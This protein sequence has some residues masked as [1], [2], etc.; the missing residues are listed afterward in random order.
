MRAQSQGAQGAPAQ[1]RGAGTT[2]AAPV[3]PDPRTMLLWEGTPPGAQGTADADIPTLT[4]Y[5]AYGRMAQTAVIVA[6]GGGYGNLAMNHEGRQVANWLNSQGIAAFV[7]KYRLGPRYHHP[8]PLT[9]ALQAIKTVRGRAKEL[10]LDPKR[11]GIWGFSAGGH[12]ASTAATQFTSSEDRPD[13]AV[14]AYPVI[15][16]TDEA[17][18]H[19]GSRRNLLGDG[20]ERSLVEKMS[21]ELRVT[22]QTPPIFLFHTNEDTGVPPENSILFY[23]ACRKAGVPVEMHIYEKGPHGVGLGWSD[24]SLSSWPARLSEWL[25]RR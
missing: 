6:P 12:L 2:P 24:L 4:Y 20:A 22:K 10:G 13:F 1:G 23:L 17:F 5:P 16:L 11:I 18:V 14:L 21:S 3:S 19:K 8:A 7:L 25:R 9:D 15:T